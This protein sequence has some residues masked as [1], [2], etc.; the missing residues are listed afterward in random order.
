M[1]SSKCMLNILFLTH[2]T[3]PIREKSSRGGVIY[4]SKMLEL[5]P[6]YG[7][8]VDIIEVRKSNKSPHK[9][10]H[11][12]KH[13][14]GVLD[15][16]RIFKKGLFLSKG[17]EFDLILTKNTLV[18]P[19]GYFLAKFLDIPHLV[20]VGALPIPDHERLDKLDEFNRKKFVRLPHDAYLTVGESGKSNLSELGIDENKIYLVPNATDVERF[21]SIDQREARDILNIDEDKNIVLFVGGL[22]KV[23]N[24]N[25]LIEAYSYSKRLKENS[26]LHLVGDGRKRKEL[27]K[28]VKN[29]DLSNRII[30]HGSKK[31]EEMPLYYAA[32]DFFVLPS[33]AEVTPRVIIEAM[34]ADLPIVASAVGDVPDMIEQGIKNKSRIFLVQNPTSVKELQ[35][36]LEKVLELN[37]KPDYDL[38]GYSW[39]NVVKKHIKIFKDFLDH[40]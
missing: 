6:S 19:F 27:E 2:E 33:K 5:L 25:T 9:S 36:Q 16:L 10:I 34:A 8:E 18:Y 40:H 23:K 29:D 38:K 30:F 3:V 1:W 35:T 26:E 24:L 21:Q 39:E 4:L 7:W 15:K 28:I 37:P 12:V 32:A 22:E 31:F 14:N 20:H 17:K 13:T 11:S